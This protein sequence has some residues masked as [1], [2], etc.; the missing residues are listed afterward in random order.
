[1]ANLNIRVDEKLK[2]D[3]E[4]IL[5]RLGLSVSDAVRLFLAQ[6]RNTRGIPFEL[7]LY[8]EPTPAAIAA[9]KEAEKELKEGK[10]PSFTSVDS[11]MTFLNED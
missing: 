8:D 7:K 11:L 2:A 6:I 9:I 1:M 10:L 3:A 5:C 4:A